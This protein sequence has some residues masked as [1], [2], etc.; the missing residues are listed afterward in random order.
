MLKECSRL[1]TGCSVDLRDEHFGTALLA[2]AANGHRSCCA[3]LITA[4]ADTGMQ[5][6]H[7]VDAIMAASRAGHH[8]VVKLLLDS[9][10]DSGQRVCTPPRHA[11][12]SAM[13]NS[14]LV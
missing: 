11:S 5:D 7:G 12:I 3:A 1:H 6:E 8:G 14:C 9:G 2:A 4:R 10:V 13:G